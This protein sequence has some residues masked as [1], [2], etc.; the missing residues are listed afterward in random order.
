MFSIAFQNI[1][2]LTCGENVGGTAYELPFSYDMLFSFT[3]AYTAWSNTMFEPVRL[4][5]DTKIAYF[6]QVDN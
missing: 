6:S 5:A 2:E 3:F 4:A 1:Y